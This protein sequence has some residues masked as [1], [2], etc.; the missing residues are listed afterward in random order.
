MWPSGLHT[1]LLAVSFVSL[2]RTEATAQIYYSAWDRLLSRHVHKGVLQNTSLDVVDYDAIAQDTDLGEALRVFE[3]VDVT[4]RWTKSQMLALH[5]NAYNAFAVN[6]IVQ[7]RCNPVGSC[8][9]LQSI[10][11]V[12]DVWTRP[13]HRLAGKNVS[14]NDIEGY[15]R[16]P[17]PWPEDPR[18]HACIVCASISCPNLRP[19]AFSPDSDVL[20][21]QMADQMRNFLANPKKGSTIAGAAA[22]AGS[23]HTTS[24]A[25]VKATDMLLLSKIFYWYGSD[26]SRS[27]SVLGFLTLYAPPHVR[28][29]IQRHPNATLNFFDYNWNVNGHLQ[30]RCL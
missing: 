9:T 3:S 6:T 20:D 23:R 22:M 27:G 21:T 13:V 10:W 14:L 28:H 29:F 30:C 8:Q 26:F 15:L 17:D 16:K 5:I 18:I 12:S 7:H 19:Q 1:L 2:C 25:I 11:N 4:S 24:R